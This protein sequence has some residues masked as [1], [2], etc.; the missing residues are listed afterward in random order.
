MLLAVGVGY[1]LRYKKWERWTPEGD[2][3]T[4]LI[5]TP[6]AFRG[7]GGLVWSGRF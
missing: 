4:A 1:H 3:K 2:K 6:A 7:G 5:P